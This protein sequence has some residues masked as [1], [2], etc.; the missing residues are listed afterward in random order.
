MPNS[1][2]L[3]RRKLLSM[4][5]M[6]AGGAVLYQAMTSLGYAAVPPY[7]GPMKLQGNPKGAKVLILGAGIAG[8]V[9]AYELR[10]AGYQVQILEYN[11]KA[12][13]RAWTIRGGDEFTELSGIKQT[14]RFDEGQYINPGPWRIPYNHYAMLDY[15][16][17]LGVGIEPFFQANYNAFVHDS[18]S[19]G[20]KPQV[21]RHVQCDYQ[22]NVAEMLAKVVGQ[23]HLDS[24][25]TKEDQQ[26][27]LESL[28]DFGALDNNYRYAKGPDSSSRRGYEVAPGGGLMP[29]VQYSTPLKLED[30]L[31]SGMWSAI[32]QG[33]LYEF[34]TSLFQPIG[35][36][37]MLPRAFER[38]L[39]S[40]LHF[41]AKIS[42]IEQT[43]K[44]VTATYTDLQTGQTLHASADW[45][46]CTLPLS[47]LSQ[48]DINVSDKMKA[49]IAAVPYD[50]AFK[51]G[52]QFKRRF[53]EDDDRIYGGITRTNLPINRISYPMAGINRPGKGVLMAAYTF[54]ADSY[55]FTAMTPDE[56]LKKVLEYGAQIH[57]QY[58]EE[59][60][61][62]IT[63]G[64]HRVPWSNGCY[65][66]WTEETRQQHYND[67]CQIDG[68]ILLAGEHA[69]FIP[70]WQEGAALSAQDAI[71]RLHQRIVG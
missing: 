56:R 51:A 58:H 64:W 60:D 7:K 57:P 13:G 70:G 49:A 28:K 47:I 42:K 67:L 16:K 48:L 32:S 1:A 35:G 36:M 50:T 34:Q 37:D 27:L 24:P 61:N 15:Y 45:C 22:G 55:K 62:G 17:E 41:N 68:R 14:C 12:G 66:L 23:G 46:I 38:E 2:E 69:S 19:F 11:A 54:G 43:D 33:Q 44:G 63:V 29:A 9:S 31:K 8:L 71:Q 4:I 10:K 26:M 39:K 3:S 53:W 40:V 20:G 30:L 65:G 52:I 25:L 6:A 18:A 5:G 59:F 21:L